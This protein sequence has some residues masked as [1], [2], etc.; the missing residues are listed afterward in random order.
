MAGAACQV[1]GGT[2]KGKMKLGN[3]K[4]K[5][6]GKPNH[7]R[8][9]IHFHLL[10]SFVIIAHIHME[11]LSKKEFHPEYHVSHQLVP[12]NIKSALFT[13]ISQRYGLLLSWNRIGQ[14]PSFQV[15]K[16]HAETE[17]SM[18]QSL[19]DSS[20][21]LKGKFLPVGGIGSNLGSHVF[22]H[23]SKGSQLSFKKGG[24]IDQN[25]AFP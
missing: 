25:G 16:G 5:A 12:K 22:Y 20:L 9:D 14:I 23:Q 7:A 1:I 21:D 15:L 10:S 11:I 17:G 3:P 4:T 19:G 6:H 18:S 24:H 8:V 13:F 2:T